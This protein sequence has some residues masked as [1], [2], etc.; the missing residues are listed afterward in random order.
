[1]VRVSVNGWINH[2]IFL[3]YATRWFR[4]MPNWQML[5]RPHLLLLDVHKSH[6]YNIHFLKLMMEFN[7]GVLAIPSHISPKI[8]PLDNAPFANFKT[9]W[10]ENLLEYLF[11]SVGCEM[12]KI[13]FFQVFWPAW[14]KAMTMANIQAGF[15]QTGIYPVNPNAQ[16]PALLGLSRATDNLTN[17]DLSD[18]GKNNVCTLLCFGSNYS[19]VLNLIDLDLSCFR[20]SHIS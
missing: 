20:I 14:Q 12:P 4:W 17:L 6:V 7:I 18:H 1:M 8:Q 9:F 13:D 11:C 16:I 19:T 2:D 15:R 10:K 3:E 5:D